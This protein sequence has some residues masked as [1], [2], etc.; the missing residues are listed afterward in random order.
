M[1][2]S[3]SYILSRHPFLTVLCLFFPPFI[4]VWFGAFLCHRVYQVWT[5]P[6]EIQ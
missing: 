5:D 2:A 4:L 6:R 1:S 3:P